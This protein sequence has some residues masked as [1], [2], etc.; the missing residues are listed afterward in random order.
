M[1]ELTIKIFRAESEEGF[2]Y[3]IY[4]RCDVDDDE[5]NPIGGGLCTGTMLEALE[6]AKDESEEII[7]GG[8]YKD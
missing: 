4:D 7:K 6:M 2:F 1:E 3:D 8:L 5:R